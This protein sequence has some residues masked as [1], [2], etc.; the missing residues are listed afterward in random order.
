MTVVYFFEDSYRKDINKSAGT[1]GYAG[2]CFVCP[3]FVCLSDS[4]SCLLKYKCVHYDKVAEAPAHHE[5]VKDLMASE[6]FV[7]VIEDRKLQCI[8]DTA[9]GVNNSPG[10]QPA[11]GCSRHRIK[12]LCKCKYAGPAH[13]DIQDR[14]HPF[15]AVYPESFDKNSDNRNPPHN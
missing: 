5:K 7:A 12:N 8:D 13:T 11:K 14:G 3:C 1:G 6:I 15:G 4:V 9:D 10:Q 2:T